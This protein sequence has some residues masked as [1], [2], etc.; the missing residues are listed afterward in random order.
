MYPNVP[1]GVIYNIQDVETTY[2]PTWIKKMQCV[3]I[4]L[5]YTAEVPRQVIW[6]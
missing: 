5:H 2:K 3:H 4:P 1:C 6:F